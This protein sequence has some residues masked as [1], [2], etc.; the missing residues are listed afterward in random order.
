MFHP[1]RTGL[2]RFSLSLKIQCVAQLWHM[3]PSTMMA[4]ASNNPKT[5]VPSL[6]DVMR[7]RG[8]W[9]AISPYTRFVPTSGIRPW[10]LGVARLL[11]VRAH[12]SPSAGTLPSLLAN[13]P[14]ARPP[15]GCLSVC[16]S[17]TPCLSQSRSQFLLH[18]RLLD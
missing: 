6:F 13:R 15:T 5:S 2:K 4:R 18:H 9:P 14:A 1:S 10:L 3:L 17:Q 8:R 12:P 16:R 11:V 7:T